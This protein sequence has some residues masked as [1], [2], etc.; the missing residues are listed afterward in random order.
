MATIRSLLPT[1]ERPGPTVT[2]QS[3]TRLQQGQA[4]PTRR[5][6]EDYRPGYPRF[7]A[8]VS[9]HAPFFMCR[10]FDKLR[11]RL[12][13]QKQDKLSMLEEKLEQV[14]REEPS[15]L[16]LGKS[17]CDQNVERASILREIDDCL[18]DFGK[19]EPLVMVMNYSF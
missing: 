2:G 10:R 3:P 18:A 19:S 15:P 11:A 5:L 16:Y 9:A 4:N 8:L 17:R 1:W 6:V 13:L 7:V 14:D 12:L